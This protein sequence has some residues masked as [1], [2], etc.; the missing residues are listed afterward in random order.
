MSFSRNVNDA[1]LMIFYS[2]SG[3]NDSWYAMRGLVQ[4]AQGAL[5]EEHNP[6]RFLPRPRVF[7][8]APSPLPFLE[9]VVW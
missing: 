5:T 2:P 4:L 1:A 9:N 8:L 6:S 3:M 7:S